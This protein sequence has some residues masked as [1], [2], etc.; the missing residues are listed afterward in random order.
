MRDRASALRLAGS[1]RGHLLTLPMFLYCVVSGCSQENQSVPVPA[2]APEP[3]WSEADEW[4]QFRGPQ[5]SGVASAQSLP[6]AWN[7]ESGE[8]I[9]WKS[10]IS[11]LGHASPIV[12]KG[13]VFVVTADNG[14]ADPELRLGLYGEIAPVQD[15]SNHE[16][17]LLCLSQQTGE[18][19][20]ERTL[21]RGVPEIKRHTKATHANST[22]ATDGKQIVVC[23]GSEGLYCLDFSGELLW[24]KDLG[25]LDSGYYSTPAAQ[26]GFAASPILYQNKVIMQC[27]VQQNSYLAAFDIDNGNELW[28]TPREDVPTWSTPTVVPGHSR[29]EIVVNGYKHAGGYDPDSGKALWKLG[30][31]GDI[32][33]PTP[34][35][36]HGLVFLSS[37]HGSNRP[38]FAIRP[39]AT[40]D[41]TISPTSE[42]PPHDALVWHQAKQGIYLQT[43][44]VVGDYLYACRN[45]GLLS[46]YEAKTGERQYR[47]RLGSG[48]A[49]FTASPV[50]ADGKLFFTC[51]DGTVFVVE[52]GPKYNLIAK[53]EMNESCMATPAIAG[54]QL[55]IRTTKEVIAIGNS[56]A[57]SSPL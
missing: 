36:A 44:I 50:A 53:N 5:A 33:V 24:K 23:L 41:L 40:G 28:R 15:D 54:G 12:S 20:W 1:L 48:K 19:L 34:I 8:N 4:R 30:G 11:G 6:S 37:A 31:G 7:V 38:L 46:C 17:K 25:R 57:N 26:W 45:N 52:P 18:F 29:T 2:S 16:W 10:P 49:G 21:Y 32:P 55:I 9:R 51:E 13:R 42:E 14:E 47:K 22:P 39:G 35:F 3:V 56:K 27:D 43:P